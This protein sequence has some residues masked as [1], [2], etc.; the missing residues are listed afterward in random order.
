MVMGLVIIL[1]VS[2]FFIIK[3]K[4]AGNIRIGYVP[5]TTA[6]P[7]YIAEEKGFF[8]D[9]GLDAVLVSCQGAVKQMEAL[10][11]KNIDAVGFMFTQTALTIE[12][13]DPGSLVFLRTDYVNPQQYQLQLV[14]GKD[15][16]INSIYDLKGKTIAEL[17]GGISGVLIK[18]I[19]KSAGLTLKDVSVVSMPL[20]QMAQAII[21][22]KVDA[23]LLSDPFTSLALR[24]GSINILKKSLLSDYL[25]DPSPVAV[26]AVRKEYYDQN[27]D[28]VKKFLKAYE[29][30]VKY[31]KQHPQESR[32]IVIKRHDFP[33]DLKLLATDM[34]DMRHVGLT[35]L[36][37]FQNK[38]F[39]EGGMDNK[40]DLDRL[41]VYSD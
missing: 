29:K 24:E 2:M 37:E 21:A 1:I 11:S 9:A 31:M 5:A 6:L 28:A 32:D 4:P 10:L 35:D 27:K 38:L 39:L 14:T 13:S 40:A 34:F 18:L 41:I 7:L 8:K 15:S 3:E 20:P 16:R 26:V 30:S 36:S 33:Q 22:G 25:L 17:G 19:L 23:A 12:A